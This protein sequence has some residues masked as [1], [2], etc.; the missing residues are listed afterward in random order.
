MIERYVLIF[1]ICSSTIILEDLH[2][3]NQSGRY[4]DLVDEINSFLYKNNIYFE[5]EVYKFLGDGFIL[6]FNENTVVESVLLFIIRLVDNCNNMLSR[7][8]DDYVEI[9]K[10]PRFGI[11]IGLDKGIIY[12]R[13]LNEKKEY[14]YKFE[15]KTP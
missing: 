10:L 13:N 12:K 3:T 2:R 11:T 7:F 1:D 14:I 9:T 8:L 5:Y 6:I 4:M 15:D